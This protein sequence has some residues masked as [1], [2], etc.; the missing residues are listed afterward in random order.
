MFVFCICRCLLRGDCGGSHHARSSKS[1]NSISSCHQVSSRQTWDKRPQERGLC[2]FYEPPAVSGASTAGRCTSEANSPTDPHF[3]YCPTDRFA[4]C[5]NIS[6]HDTA[7]GRTA[8]HRLK[9][10]SQPIGTS[11]EDPLLY[12]SQ[13]FRYSR[14]HLLLNMRQ[15]DTILSAI[16]TVEEERAL[17][18]NCYKRYHEHA[19]R[20]GQTLI[21]LTFISQS[22]P[23]GSHSLRPPLLPSACSAA[24]RS[25]F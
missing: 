6:S 7:A 18:V 5:T 3:R 2:I 4:P 24:R 21:F 12:L 22:E 17:H 20:L 15:V 25:A 16:I 1:S 13:V 19:W 11:G 8:E 10:L 14:A 23:S 9:H